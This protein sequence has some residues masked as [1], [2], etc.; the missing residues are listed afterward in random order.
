M[1]QFPFIVIEGLDG[2]GKTTVRKGLFRLWENLYGVTPL[3]V[4]TNNF[5][6]TDAA[7][8]I[9]AGKYTPTPDNRDTYL[10][11]LAAEKAA[12]LTRLVV[13]ALTDRPVI[14]DRW[15]I[16]ELAFFAVKHDLEPAQTYEELAGEITEAADLTVVLD[17]DPNDSIQRAG[18]RSGDA[19]RA[20]WDVLDVQTRVRDVYAAVVRDAAAYPLL[21][22]VAHIDAT[23]SPDAVLAQV[24]QALLDRDLVPSLAP[25]A[26]TVA[27]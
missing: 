22:P 27:Q 2:T 12:T 19:V 14:S 1:R 24:W 20:D 26:A 15:L 21:G 18:S 3:C 6:A 10:R 13:P 11:A 5:I 17:L 7:A 8:D 23:A 9:V 16:S 4:L 25:L